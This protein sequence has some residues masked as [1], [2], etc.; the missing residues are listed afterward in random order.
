M[1][2]FTKPSTLK[3]IYTSHF[4]VN[5]LPFRYMIPK[6]F[7]FGYLDSHKWDFSKKY[8]VKLEVKLVDKLESMDFDYMTKVEDNRNHMDHKDEMDRDRMDN[9][10]E[11]EEVE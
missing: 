3:G 10:Q 11:V 4:R 8:M 2:Y 5:H 9:K 6:T 1:S 7:Y